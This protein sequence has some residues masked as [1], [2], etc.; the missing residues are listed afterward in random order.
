MTSGHTVSNTKR[1][2][3]MEIGFKYS[4]VYNRSQHTREYERWV[5]LQELYNSVKCTTAN[6]YTE[7]N[8]Y[9]S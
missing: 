1:L 9:F 4:D 3:L 6:V 2:A 8:I 5:D 7:D